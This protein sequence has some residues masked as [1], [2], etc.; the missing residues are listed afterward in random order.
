M[1]VALLITAMLGFGERPV[2]DV[3]LAPDFAVMFVAS[4][5]RNSVAVFSSW[6]ADRGYIFRTLFDRDG[7]VVDDVA[8]WKSSSAVTG[9]ASDGDRYLATL[10]DGGAVLLDGDGN[11]LRFIETPPNSMVASNGAGF[12][13][14]L[15]SPNAV[16]FLDRDGVAIGMPV[17]LP[18]VARAIGGAG[19]DYIVVTMTS[20][21][22]LRHGVLSEP[23]YTQTDRLQAASIASNGDQ[24]I[25]A[26]S[27]SGRT[28][29]LPIVRGVAGRPKADLRDIYTSG[30]L[31][32]GTEFLFWYATEQGRFVAHLTT[33]AVV[34]TTE[35]LSVPPG[36]ATWD[37]RRLLFVPYTFTRFAPE[38]LRPRVAT[39]GETTL[40]G[41][42]EFY[43]TFHLS[44]VSADGTHMDAGVID[45]GDSFLSAGA[46]A[47]DGDK[48]IIAYTYAP[49]YPE[50]GELRFRRMTRGAALGAQ[51]KVWTGPV[52]SLRIASS[53][54]GHF[55]MVWETFDPVIGDE[56]D[57]TILASIDG[58]AP[59][60]IATGASYPDI[61]WDGRE[62]RLAWI[63]KSP[64]RIAFASLSRTGK[65]LPVD[66][67]GTLGIYPPRVAGRFG[68]FFNGC[69]IPAV[70]RGALDMP[71]HFGSWSRDRFWSVPGFAVD[72]ASNAVVTFDSAAILLGN[73]DRE[74]HASIPDAHDGEVVHTRNGWLLV[75]MREVDAP[76]YMHGSRVFI[77][78]LD[79]TQARTRPIR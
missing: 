27:F 75:Y 32:T 7:N 56:K 20:V 62:F 59:I 12:V 68:L 38:Q 63:T 45:L 50:P 67:T 28:Q 57:A 2:S 77:R 47:F 33:G 53:D 3:H 64:Q 55:A 41:W 36:V 61:A 72:D 13:V 15:T 21:R 8:I 17:A 76:P 74:L 19:S 78:T 34:R 71:L 9:I 31:W 5:G 51:T 29:L 60:T 66:A 11:F 14:V 24:A 44:L 30:A 54:D 39:D 79:F 46:V 43:Y 52:Y 4:N 48:W 6:R 40:V 1:R 42:L 49:P 70:R 18:D 69:G 16:Q 37:G 26:M 35:R 23:I 25:V 73:D 58:G 65:I 22:M 10:E